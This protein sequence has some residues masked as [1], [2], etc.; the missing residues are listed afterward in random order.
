[1]IG[2]TVD[3]VMCTNRLSPFLGDALR[4]LREQ[5]YTRWALYL[6]DDGSSVPDELDGVV[7]GLPRTTVIHRPH[8]GPATARNAAIAA[9]AGELVTFLDDDDV[10]PATRLEDTVR[11]L[12][13]NPD[14]VGAYGD[15]IDIDTEGRPFGG[16]TT[17]PATRDEILDGSGALPRIT[18]L[19]LRRRAL[20]SIGPFTDGLYLAEDTELTLRATRHGPLVST[21]TT[22]VA[23][24]RHG[25]NATNR[26]DWRRLHRAGIHAIALNRSDAAS[27]GDIR[28]ARLLGEN[29]RHYDRAAAAEG[30]GRELA[31][32]RRGAL[33][34]ALRDARDSMK[35]SPVGFTRGAAARL[36]S[37]GSRVAAAMRD[38][39]GRIVH[40]AL[41]RLRRG[42]RTV[43]A[44]P[45]VGLRLGNYLYLWLQAHARS[46]AGSPTVVLDARGMPEWLGRIPELRTY[47]ITRSELSM[48]DRR[49]W[50]A[51]FLYQ[52]FGVD[53]TVDQ[54]EDFVRDVLAPHVM[55]DGSD[56]LVVNVR[57]GDF[58]AEFF[59]KHAFDQEGYLAEAL[60]IS[61]GAERILVVSDDP[62]WCRR[63]LRD[64][65]SRVTRLVEYAEADPWQNFQAV[66]GSRRIIGT[67]STFT[68]WAAYTAGVIHADAQ[69]I[70]P[71]FHARSSDGRT[72]AHQL[73]PRWT[74]VEGHRD[75]P[76]RRVFG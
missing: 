32:L 74:V 10:W 8:A 55:P 20:D 54:V 7:G 49:M 50:D 18:T 4:S 23:Y 56:R 16:W 17:P 28:A 15:G 1:M 69:I 19:T 37:R 11:A 64:P 13:S 42:E 12:A 52:R 41:A 21:G 70:M 22:L 29:R 59:H 67:N 26:A 43:I 40:P 57:R 72:D 24:R 33:G 14:A 2:P 71:R 30:P 9:G 48:R 3:V 38:R 36:T 31:L 58:Y 61:G 62:D 47:T 66:A 35:L 44:T 65:L 60:R 34:A 76:D 25:T 53:F 73:H 68:Y 39:A 45:R 27:S 63:N 51:E 5:T 6:V 75:P 46:A